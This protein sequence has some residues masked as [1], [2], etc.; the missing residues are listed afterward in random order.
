MKRNSVS[1]FQHQCPSSPVVL[2]AVEADRDEPVTKSGALD[3]SAVSPF[4][5]NQAAA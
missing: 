4:I 5:S 3:G 2:N 1:E